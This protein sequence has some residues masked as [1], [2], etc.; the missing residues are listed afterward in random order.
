MGGRTGTAASAAPLRKSKVEPPSESL[1]MEQGGWRCLLHP[2]L[3]GATREAG[4]CCR[5][6]PGSSLLGSQNSTHGARKE[7]PEGLGMW[8]GGPFL[9]LSPPSLATQP[10]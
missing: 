8:T 9:D 6:S 3:S 4:G 5:P 2:A 1:Q 7:G 10:F